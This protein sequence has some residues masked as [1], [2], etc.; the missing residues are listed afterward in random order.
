MLS[1]IFR[2]QQIQTHK[3]H[4]GHEVVKFE[5]GIIYNML[6]GL[7]SSHPIDNA[8]SVVSVY[9]AVVN[10]CSLRIFCSKEST[11]L[12]DN[13][14]ER[15]SYYYWLDVCVRIYWTHVSV[16]DV[17]HL[18]C[19]CQSHPSLHDFSHTFGPCFLQ[20]RVKKCLYG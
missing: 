14:D 20:V 2:L 6:T 7:H 18:L 3:Y 1:I 13:D 12:H 10:N 19:S 15:I 4:S 8:L 16:V 17:S 5:F 9:M 11:F